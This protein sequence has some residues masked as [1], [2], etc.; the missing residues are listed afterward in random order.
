MILVFFIVLPGTAGAWFDGGRECRPFST[1]TDFNSLESS[2]SLAVYDGIAAGSEGVVVPPNPFFV[3]VDTINLDIPLTLL[4]KTPVSSMEALDRLM[5]ANMR[6]KLLIDEYNAL[7][8]RADALL[9]SVSIPYLDSP[10]PPPGKGGG[11]S[12]DDQKKRLDTRLGGIFFEG[13]ALNK[14]QSALVNLPPL[15]FTT[16]GVPAG[17]KGSSKSIPPN[18]SPPGE[19]HNSTP[20]TQGVV[21]LGSA[22][23]TKDL[24]WIFAL[25]LNASSY[26]LTHRLEA[27]LY[28]TFLF[29]FGYLLS[30]QVRHG[31]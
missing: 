7:Q 21:P 8:K 9:K 19:N 14:S 28:G 1:R 15:G 11:N 27:V 24:P 23:N 12:L 3:P 4:V 6:L 25:F 10:R 29:L 5:V 22:S 17:G 30:L 18:A 31:K 26:C 13:H 2:G 16:G 20:T